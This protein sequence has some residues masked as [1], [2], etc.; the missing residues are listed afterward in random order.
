MLSTRPFVVVGLTLLLHLVSPGTA[1]SQTTSLVFKS[2]AGDYIGGGVDQT[3]T[4]ADGIFT[5]LRN[6]GNGVAINFNGGPHWWSLHFAAPLDAPLV[7]GL[8]ENATRWPFQS[9]TGPGM[10][11]SGE[12][13][14][15]NTLTGRFEVLEAVYSATGEVERFAATF[16]QH[17]EG[18]VPALLGSVLFNSTLPPPPPPPTVCQAKVATIPALMREVGM[19]PT[20]ERTLNALHYFLFAA[21]WGLDNNHARFA[22]S[23]L[24]QF[25]ERAVHAS[26]LRPENPNAITVNAADSLACGASNVLTNITVPR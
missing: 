26:N 2:Q 18:G 10:D 3:F 6:F 22:R 5:A 21:Q 4:P 8:Y 25:I 19:L 20:S 17:C 16:E 24:A 15:C 1:A 12:G 23:S 9:P 11:I 13:R 7:P 14:G